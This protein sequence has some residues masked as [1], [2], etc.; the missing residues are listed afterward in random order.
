M[1]I[2]T[3]LHMEKL[4]LHSVWVSSYSPYSVAF[5]F[6]VSIDP[7][8]VPLW[9]DVDRVTKNI[10]SIGILLTISTH[11]LQRE[12]DKHE[13][14]FACYLIYYSLVMWYITNIG[15]YNIRISHHFSVAS[16]QLQSSLVCWWCLYIEF[17]V[18]SVNLIQEYW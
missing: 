7:Q 15:S 16:Y 5:C 3:F 8:K 13:R 17:H 12:S 14:A 9:S 10:P 6:T 18:F 4:G 2:T 11:L 1:L